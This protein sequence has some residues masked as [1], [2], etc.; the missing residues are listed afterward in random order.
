MATSNKAKDKTSSAGAKI[1]VTDD[2]PYLVSGGIPLAEE[3]I[4][5]DS[6]GA[7]WKWKDGKHFP[8]KEKYALCRCGESSNKPY[9]DGTHQKVDFDGTETA[10]REPYL[11]QAERTDGPELTLTDA[12]D[13]CA[14]ARF[15]DRAGG[16]WDLVE[17]SDDPE[18][19]RTAIQ[20]AAD[21]SSGRLVVWDEKGRVIEPHLKPAIKVTEDPPAKASGPLWVQG[22]IPI[23]SA[24]GEVYE[25]RNRV[26]LCRCGRSSNKPFCDSTHVQG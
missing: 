7:A 25:K 9:C 12:I 6:D 26:T 19:K 3:S 5:A 11:N 13:L 10:S 15:C 23:E 21:C 24:D 16:I 14:G 1:K 4:V 17:Q 20:E 18:A 2:G 22:G 8:A